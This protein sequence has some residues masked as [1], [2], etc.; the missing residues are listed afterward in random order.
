MIAIKMKQN[1]QVR[2]CTSSLHSCPI[3]IGWVGSPEHLKLFEKLAGKM[4]DK[5]YKILSD[6][7]QTI[8]NRKIK[9]SFYK[10][11]NLENFYDGINMI[12]CYSEESEEIAINALCNGIPVVIKKGTPLSNYLIGKN[13]G[14]LTSD[15]KDLESI[16]EKTSRLSVE[17]IHE[18]IRN[19]IKT[20]Y[21]LN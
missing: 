12:F 8:K 13:L 10:P 11:S 19:I 16:I 18:N 7:E 14:I 15:F 3:K 9:Y 4:Y 17:T 5:E 2:D 21:K 6:E 20:Y 1:Y